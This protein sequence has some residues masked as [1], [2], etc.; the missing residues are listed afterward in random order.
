L[1]VRAAVSAFR[2]RCLTTLVD[3]GTMNALSLAGFLLSASCATSAGA[4]VELTQAMNELAFSSS[5]STSEWQGYCSRG[6]ISCKDVPES[7]LFEVCDSKVLIRQIPGLLQTEK[8]VLGCT[9][10]FLQAKC[11]RLAMMNAPKNPATKEQCTTVFLRYAES[12]VDDALARGKTTKADISKWCSGFGS[13]I[14]ALSKTYSRSFGNVDHVVSLTE[15]EAELQNAWD[16]VHVVAEKK[17]VDLLQEAIDA[18]R[19][20]EGAVEAAQGLLTADFAA[21]TAPQGNTLSVLCGAF[22]NGMCNSSAGMEEWSTDEGLSC[23][24]AVFTQQ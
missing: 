18:I 12:V 21:C 16:K 17:D 1:S 13:F 23:S 9:T 19:A 5:V 24:S 14:K 3:A 20:A 22:Q 6:G 7:K 8:C 2:R 4:R 11:N 10:S 15:T